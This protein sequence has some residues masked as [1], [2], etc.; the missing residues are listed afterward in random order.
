MSSPFPTKASSKIKARCVQFFA[1]VVLK[2]LLILSGWTKDNCGR[3][4][5]RSSGGL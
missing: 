1:S 5:E 3:E 4:E 2:K